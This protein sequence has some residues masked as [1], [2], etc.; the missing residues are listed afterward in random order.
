MKETKHQTIYYKF[1]IFFSYSQIFATTGFGVTLFYILVCFFVGT[2]SIGTFVYAVIGAEL[3]AIFTKSV[4]ATVEDVDIPSEQF[5]DL[6][7]VKLRQAADLIINHK[8]FEVFIT[9]VI[10]LDI[11][12]AATENLEAYEMIAESP[13]LL[14]LVLLLDRVIIINYLL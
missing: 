6:R 3:E 9:F 10:V 11:A 4:Q 12:F 1:E 14:R 2:F 5:R 7:F 13:T 8:A